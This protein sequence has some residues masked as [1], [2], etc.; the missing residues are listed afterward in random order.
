M[1]RS[2]SNL[3][4]PKS[5]RL[6]YKVT[7]LV[8]EIENVPLVSGQ[9]YLKV[10]LPFHA[11]PLAKGKKNFLKSKLYPLENHTVAV[12]WELQFESNLVREHDTIKPSLITISIKKKDKETSKSSERVG[13]VDIDLAQFAPHKISSVRR[14][15]K[16]CKMNSILKVPFILT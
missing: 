6:K 9:F 10:K 13:S 12:E 2:V 8:H 7:L 15:L 3:L 14:L 16:N 11:S 1:K 4:L 5:K